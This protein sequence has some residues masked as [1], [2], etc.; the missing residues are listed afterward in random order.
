[1]SILNMSWCDLQ[2][3]RHC[4]NRTCLSKGQRGAKAKHCDAWLQV[5]RAL[6]KGVQ[7]AAVKLLINVDAAQLAVFSR[8]RLDA[9]SLLMQSVSTQYHGRHLIDEG[10]LLATL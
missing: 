8:V 1:M 10:A 3:V 7:D 2:G 9:G 6:R 4:K 5:Y